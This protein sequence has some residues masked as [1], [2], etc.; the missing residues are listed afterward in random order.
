M[1]R[2]M[3]NGKNLR[4]Q[5]RRKTR[6]RRK[7]KKDNSKQATHTRAV[8]PAI[9]LQAG[10]PSFVGRKVLAPPARAGQSLPLRAGLP[11]ISCG[12]TPKAR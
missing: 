10:C 1:S 12:F 2:R 11:E 9:H 7:R 3:P 6:R 8:R 5:R 4:L